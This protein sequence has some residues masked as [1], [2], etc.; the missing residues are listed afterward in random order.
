MS[1][2][3]AI[4]KKE[5]LSET[6]DV[7]CKECHYTFC[8]AHLSVTLKRVNEKNMH[9]FSFIPH[10]H[11][12]PIY[13]GNPHHLPEFLQ[14]VLRYYSGCSYFDKRINSLEMELLSFGR[15][16]PSPSNHLLQTFYERRQAYTQKAVS[17]LRTTAK[18]EF[19]QTIDDFFP[20]SDKG[21]VI[22]GK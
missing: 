12:I 17:H 20:Y 1:V 8:P 6:D 11:T 2:M 14:L 9:C 18:I 7:L 16:S 21:V 5:G 10:V 13:D 22:D 3:E 19:H 15:E 4:V